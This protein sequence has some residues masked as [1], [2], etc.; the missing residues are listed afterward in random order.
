MDATSKRIDGT[1]LK[2]NENQVVRVIGK[3][4][5]YEGEYGT[6]TS[7]GD[8]KLNF[9]TWNAELD[10]KVNNFYE[11]IGRVNDNLTISV[12]SVI[13]INDGFNLENYYQLV[14]FSNKVPEL[15]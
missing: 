15:F 7:N 10:I 6:L 12:Y 2:A 14:K 5:Q 11:I 13:D 8:V 3:L 9:G 4:E 1:L